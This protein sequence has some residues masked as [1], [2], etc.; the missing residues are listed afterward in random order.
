[1]EALGVDLLTLS[2]HKF[3][4]PKGVGAIYL[5]GKNPRV[6][7]TPILFGGGHERG[8]RSGTLNVPGIVG[9]GAAAEIAVREMPEESPRLKV[10]RDRLWRGLAALEGVSCNGHPTERLP[11]NLNV[12]FSGISADALM[13]DVKEV[14]MSS[15]SA[16]S[17][18]Q[19]EPSHV[20]LALGLSPEEAKASLR[21]GLGRW[22]TEE[23]IDRAVERVMAGV[24]RLR[25]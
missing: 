13:M 17:S 22:T 23:E 2:A 11:N 24:S 9:M 19:P 8:F 16:C 5:R 25:A 21:F 6:R 1:M 7:P 12:T 14:A 20:L 3:Y 18:A 15:G 10:L 4:G